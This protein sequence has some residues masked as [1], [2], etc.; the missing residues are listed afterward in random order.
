MR[1]LVWNVRGLRGKEREVGKCVE[2]CD[3]VGLV[4]TW[5]EADDWE[6]VKRKLPGGFEWRVEVAVR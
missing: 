2:G 5:T 6:A 3:V 4:E 1:V